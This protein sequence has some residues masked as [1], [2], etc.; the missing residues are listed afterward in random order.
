LHLA[1]I[2]DRHLEGEAMRRD[3]WYLL[4]ALALIAAFWI[5]D[6][7]S[8]GRAT[9]PTSEA[10][11][12][13]IEE[14]SAGAIMTVHYPGQNKIYVY[15]APFLNGPAVQC[16]YVFTLGAPGEPVTREVCGSH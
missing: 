5:G 6:A 11:Q 7:S 2:F 14:A 10:P 13:R 3:R 16:T 15:Q 1:N 12:V 8:R 9:P 4:G